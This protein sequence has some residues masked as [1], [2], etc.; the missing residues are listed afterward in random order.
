MT[1]VLIDTLYSAPPLLKH[2]GTA[3]VTL[4]LEESRTSVNTNS[5]FFWLHMVDF[6]AAQQ[7]LELR[8]FT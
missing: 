1:T 3:S 4:H 8:F 5:K 2:V 7:H 6:T